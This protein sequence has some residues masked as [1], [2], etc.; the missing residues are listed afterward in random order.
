MRASGATAGILVFSLISSSIAPAWAATDEERSAARAAASQGADAYDA[1]KWQDAIDMFTRA[2]QLVHSPIHLMFIARAELKLFEWVKAYETFNRVKREGVPADASPAVKKAVEDASNELAKLE[3]QMPYIASRIKNPSGDVKVMMD[4]T[5]VPP[6]MVGLMR[7]VNPGQHRF[8]A[9]SG[10][11]ASDVVTVDVQPASK[12]TVELELKVVTPASPALAAAPVA[13]A[14]TPTPAVSA[15]PAADTAADQGGGA[16]GMR[17]A[18]YSAFGVG[19]VGLAVGTVFL[20]QSSSTQNKADALCPSSPCDPSKK[21]AISSKDKDAASQR[22]L[23]AVGLGVGGAAVAAGVVLFVLSN[24][25]NKSTASEPG[26][27][28]FIGY[29]TAGLSGRF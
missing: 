9:L 11:L 24:G 3:P 8:Q 4:G 18:S 22:T 14:P 2:E 23:G 20:L 26:V 29:R 25:S 17:I 27:T 5:Q 7:P 12:Q 21:D 6:A 10:Q 28:P 16:N 13:A 1:G 15:P 19:V